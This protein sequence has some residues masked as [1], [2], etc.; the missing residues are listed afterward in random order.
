MFTQFQHSVYER[1]IQTE[2]NTTFKESILE[3]CS[4][5]PNDSGEYLCTANNGFSSASATNPT[6][7]TVIPGI[8]VAI[9]IATE[10]MRND[11]VK[12]LS[13]L[14]AARYH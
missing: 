7:L 4:A 3:I 8:H 10:I 11:I 1:Q 5:E 2:L 9:I 6:N 14:T 12:G 13:F